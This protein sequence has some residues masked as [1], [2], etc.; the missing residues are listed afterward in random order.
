MLDQNTC[1]VLDAALI[2]TPFYGGLHHFDSIDS[3]NTYALDQA[4]L[5]ARHG[6]FYL[7]D[8]QTAGRGRSDH[9]WV[10]NAGQG[11]YLTALLRPD[12]DAADLVWLPLI[13][14]LAAHRAIRDITALDID[15]RW[16]NDLLAGPRKVGGILVE[17]QTEAGRATA[18][19]V[20]VGINLHQRSF[21]IGLA[22]EPTSLDLETGRYASRDEL[23]VALL[24]ALAAEL[25][26]L[27]SAT[28]RLAIPARIAAISTWVEG[29]R[30]E[31]H[32][33]QP[34]VGITAGLDDRGFLRVRTT[35]GLVTVT[36]GGIRAAVD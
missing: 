22:T 27:G 19:V 35:G 12:L 23:M 32:G 7:A 24:Q 31:V 11:L 3:T 1:E 29:R 10:S 21:P 33:P 26:Q 20:G 30:V 5:G 13:A 9:Q 8:E 16:P 17:A 6:S 18:A 36:T 14:G 4:R 15:L 28:R 25:E 2:G 34:C